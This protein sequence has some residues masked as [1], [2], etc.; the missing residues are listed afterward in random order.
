M[1][2]QQQHS[3]QVVT[4][5]GSSI[6]SFWFESRRHQIPVVL[7]DTII[8]QQT[9]NALKDFKRLMVGRKN[10]FVNKIANPMASDELLA[11]FNEH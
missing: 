10:C 8:S 4:V 7:L 9:G 2:L 1:P 5:K 11:M 3:G 6:R